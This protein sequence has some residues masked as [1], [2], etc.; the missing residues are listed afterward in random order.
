MFTIDDFWIDAGWCGALGE[1]KYYIISTVEDIIENYAFNHK[2]RDKLKEI[3][4]K[5]F[6]KSGDD[7]I[8]S[9]KKPNDMPNWKWRLI[10]ES[11]LLDEHCRSKHFTVPYGNEAKHCYLLLVRNPWI[12]YDY[13]YFLVE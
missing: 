8:A 9:F 5:L 11:Q 2:K 3:L 4:L 1:H 13:H 12:G 6:D 10:T 7:I